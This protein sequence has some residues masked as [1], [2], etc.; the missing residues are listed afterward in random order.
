MVREAAGSTGPRPQGQLGAGR[1][2]THGDSAPEPAEHRLAFVRGEPREHA[3][4][5]RP[6]DRRGARGRRAA[7]SVGGVAGLRVA[8][9]NCRERGGGRAASGAGRPSGPAF[10]PLQPP[11]GSQGRRRRPGRCGRR[12]LAPRAGP[13]RPPRPLSFLPSS[14][15]LTPSILRAGGIKG[16]SALQK[17]SL[18]PQPSAA[19]P[20]VLFLFCFLAASQPLVI[21]WADPRFTFKFVCVPNWPAVPPFQH[22][23]PHRRRN[24]LG[25]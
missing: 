12:A 16:A 8:G 11:G 14:C 6:G 13:G 20:I 18:L 2:G 23:N 5:A 9:D 7:A 3:A 22:C 1:C 25:D 15:A 19:P 24:E 17:P 4:R 10:L 21:R